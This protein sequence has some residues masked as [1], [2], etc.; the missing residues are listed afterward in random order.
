MARREAK[1]KEFVAPVP[2]RPNRQGDS[3]G[4]R[5]PRGFLMVA[6]ARFL[7]N[8]SFRLVFPFLPL[9][10]AGLGVSLATM[11]GALG[12]RDLTGVVS[13]ALGRAADRRGHANAMA[14]GMAVLAVALT[15]QGASGG[16]VLFTLA[17]IGVSLAKSLFD[18]GSV[19]WV[20]DAVPF[21]KRGR[22]IGFIEMSWALAFVIGMPAAALIIGVTTWR[23]PF[24]L[25]AGACAL[26][27]IT[28]HARLPRPVRGRVVAAKLTWSRAIGGGVGALGLMGIAHSVMLVSFAAWLEDEH[29]L[30]VSGLG[31]TAIVI[32]LAELGGSGG[33]ASLSDR[34]GLS[35]SVQVSLALAVPASLLV[36]AGSTSLVVAF[37]VMAGYFLVVEFAIVAMISLFSELD[38][39]ARGTVIGVAFAAFT[40]GHAVGAVLGTQLYE[41]WGMSVNAVVMAAAFGIASSL[42]YVFI[43]DPDA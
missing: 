20:S 2:S 10:S 41:R 32:G 14:A 9:I 28:I 4:S 37:A 5:L 29:A 33:S 7:S 6:V 26:M 15:V 35:R 27:A 31:L 21:S 42:V 40:V 36:P 22:A 19:A 24:F 17:L 34:F 38:R 12:A 25:A 16:L 11:G 39:D 3:D 23:S 1:D 30:S 8:V 13:P 43:G 18:V